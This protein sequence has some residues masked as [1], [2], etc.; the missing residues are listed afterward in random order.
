MPVR[1]ASG[2]YTHL[3]LVQ[4]V[5]AQQPVLVYV[6]DL[7]YPLERIKALRLEGM[8][9]RVVERGR[10]VQD[11]LLGKVEH[12]GDVERE[13]CGTLHDRLDFLQVSVDSTGPSARGLLEAD[14]DPP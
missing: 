4:L 2:S 9:A 8:F 1:R 5:G 10:R 11:S 7:E 12:L 3:E 14:P 13:Q 6:A